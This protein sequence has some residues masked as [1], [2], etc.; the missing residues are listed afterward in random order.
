[1]KKGNIMNY[2]SYMLLVSF[3]CTTISLFPWSFSESISN[4]SS[5][6]T[7]WFSK[8]ETQSSTKEYDIPDQ[9]PIILTNHAGTIT[10]TTWNKKAMMVEAI[11]KGTEDQIKT[12]TFSV[13]IQDNAITINTSSLVPDQKPAMIDFNLIIP[14]SS[15][16]TIRLETGSLHFHEGVNM[17]DVQTNNGSIIIENATKSVIAHAPRG[18]IIIE[19]QILSSNGSFLLEAHDNITFIL[20]KQSNINLSAKTISGKIYSNL[21]IT[22][23]QI[24]TKLD[25]ESYKRMQREVIGTIGNGG[26]P[27]T[28][29]SISGT[30]QIVES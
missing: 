7:T 22:L 12:S 8:Q 24:T 27:V 23:D 4:A 2:L 14:K 6:V 17:L 13:H 29:E 28:L 25:K 16:L 1:M 3:C 9:V 18:S 19:Q 5:K 10:V 11:K 20:P 26:I 15:P 21:F 30:I